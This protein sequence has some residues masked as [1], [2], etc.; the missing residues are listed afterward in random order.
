VTILLSPV[1]GDSSAVC[2]WFGDPAGPLGGRR[3]SGNDLPDR[4]WPRRDMPE[5]RPAWAGR[6][7]GRAVCRV[8]GPL[9]A[10]RGPAGRRRRGTIRR[11]PGSRRPRRAPA[12]RSRRPG[13]LRDRQQ[14][15]G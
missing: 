3:R 1:S 11:R 15:Q 14:W 4:R 7:L 13:L 8:R 9:A 5:P 2:G 6:V 10:S 12:T